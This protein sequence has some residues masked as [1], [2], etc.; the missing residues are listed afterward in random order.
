MFFKDV[1]AELGRE[2][3]NLSEA[4]VSMSSLGANCH[5]FP[6]SSRKETETLQRERAHSCSSAAPQDDRLSAPKDDMCLL[7]LAD[8]TLY[9]ALSD[10][11]LQ[12]YKSPSLY[13]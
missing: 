5:C 12:V 7:S 9:P 2:A 6:Y 1:R 10:Q 8:L 13:I 4:F 3:E 11:P